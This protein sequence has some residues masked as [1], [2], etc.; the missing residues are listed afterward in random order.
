MLPADY[1]QERSPYL[2]Q[3]LLSICIVSVFVD[4]LEF[5]K[6]NKKKQSDVI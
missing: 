3:I 4:I 5:D 6:A 1:L 2:P